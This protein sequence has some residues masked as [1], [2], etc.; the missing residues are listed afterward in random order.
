M[1][2]DLETNVWEGDLDW[3][4]LGLRV[5]PRS[6]G[7]LV[8][9]GDLYLN[10]NEFEELPVEAFRNVE[11]AGA[12]HFYDNPVA[13]HIARAYC[14]EEADLPQFERLRVIYSKFNRLQSTQGFRW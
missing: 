6:F 5:L 8:I 4:G 14:E 1:R 12:C 7:C 2:A 3:S 11:V 9:A 13:D 10:D